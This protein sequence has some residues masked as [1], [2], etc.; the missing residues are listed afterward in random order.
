MGNSIATWGHGVA[1][2]PSLGNLGAYVKQVNSIPMLTAEREAQLAEEL[3]GG[4]IAAAKE[5]VMAHLRLVVKIAREHSGYGMPQEDLIQEGNVGL[6][7]AVK[8]FDPARGARLASYAAIWI[9]SEMQEYIL[10]NWRIV[11]IGS[12]K[13][14]RKLFFNLRRL[15]EQL[16]GSSRLSQRDEIAK[17]LGVEA[18]EV[19][20]AIQWFSGGEVG[21]LEG[22]DE[23]E[24]GR[25]F[26]ALA[27]DESGEP[28]SIALE[29]QARVRFPAALRTAIENLPERERRVILARYPSHGEPATLGKIASELGVSLERV[30]QIEAAALKRMREQSGGLKAWL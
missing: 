20:K 5:L 17:I 16:H 30:R 13:G 23:P 29:A 9:K 8:K 18:A 6:M 7:M 19:D 26:L 11:K 28:E 27:A 21:I 4:S 25:A 2:A 12:A 24:E 3:L 15:Q 10:S 1:A 14:L 22:A